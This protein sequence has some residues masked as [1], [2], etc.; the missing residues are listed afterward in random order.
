MECKRCGKDYTQPC[1]V[2]PHCNAPIP[3]RSPDPNWDGVW[4][5]P[6]STDRR[7][8]RVVR[9]PDET[10]D[11]KVR[12]GRRFAYLTAFL[13]PTMF[14]PFALYYAGVAICNG[15]PREGWTT[16]AITVTALAAYAVLYAVLFK[17]QV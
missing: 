15:R 16:V 13:L 11:D 17:P 12:I 9:A 6:V 7:V 2:C 10:I 3:V 8:M 5:P 4:P 1:D 14:F